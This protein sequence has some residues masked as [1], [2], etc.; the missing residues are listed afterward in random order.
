M[1]REELRDQEAVEWRATPQ[2]NPPGRPYGST[3]GGRAQYSAMESKCQIP[4]SLD[5][6]L[7]SWRTKGGDSYGKALVAL[8]LS[9][10]LRPGGFLIKTHT[11]TRYL[12][13]LNIVL[14]RSKL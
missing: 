2:G 1:L 14:D 3:F 4:F 7:Y 9:S 8:Q 13:N 12:Q 5:V 10:V 6:P 11:T